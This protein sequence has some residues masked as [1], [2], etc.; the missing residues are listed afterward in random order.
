M[1]LAVA[2]VLLAAVAGQAQAASDPF[3]DDL[4]ALAGC[5]RRGGEP[6][7]FTL[8]H[9]GS[10]MATACG[11]EETPEAE[12][13]CARIQEQPPLEFIDSYPRRIE[14]CLRARGARPEITADGPDSG[15]RDGRPMITAMVGVLETG[16]RFSLKRVARD[17]I[18]PDAADY[19]LEITR[20][21][22]P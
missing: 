10:E 21:P 6:A 3:C 8:R 14:A 5:A 13:L 22:R 1:R 2:I 19:R 7:A 11:Y 9:L 16:E 12:A 18:L 15:F 4:M 20:P 17:D